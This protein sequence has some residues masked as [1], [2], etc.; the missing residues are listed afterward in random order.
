MSKY[1]NVPFPNDSGSVCD[2][3][4]KTDNA[5]CENCWDRET[6]CLTIEF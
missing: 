6:E 5:G 1:T 3:L 2:K 4:P